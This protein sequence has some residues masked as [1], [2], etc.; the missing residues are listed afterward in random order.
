MHQREEEIRKAL[1]LLTTERDGI[2][3][4]LESANTE[5]DLLYPQISLD[6]EALVLNQTKLNF[7]RV[8]MTLAQDRDAKLATNEKD[9]RKE[10]QRYELTGKGL[11]SSKEYLEEVAK[12]SLPCDAATWARLKAD[13]KLQ[14][15]MDEVYTEPPDDDQPY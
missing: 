9:L 10:L 2:A 3:L 11:L 12:G 6:A 13:E 14:K 5:L 8:R 15:A 4:S 1:K 7:L